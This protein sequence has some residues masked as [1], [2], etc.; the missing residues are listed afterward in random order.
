M[1]TATQSVENQA[2]AYDIALRTA[3]IMS[4]RLKRTMKMI[5][6]ITFITTMSALSLYWIVGVIQIVASL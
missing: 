5:A 1:K 3:N 2:L 4:Y 6:F